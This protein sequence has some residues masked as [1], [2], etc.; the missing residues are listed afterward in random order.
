[1]CIHSTVASQSANENGTS[2]VLLLRG[3]SATFPFE[4]GTVIE[5]GYFSS[6]TY[7]DEG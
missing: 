5:T 4:N 7:E 2:Q 3:N 1:M 6:T